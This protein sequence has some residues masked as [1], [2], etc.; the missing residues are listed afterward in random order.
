[1]SS[2]F[3]WKCFAQL[4][5]VY[6]LGWCFFVKRKFAQKLA[7]WKMLVK[8]TK[9]RLANREKILEQLINTF[10]NALQDEFFEVGKKWQRFCIF[11][12]VEKSLWSAVDSFVHFVIRGYINEMFVIRV[13]NNHN[14]FLG[15]C[16]ECFFS[17]E[18]TTHLHFYSNWKCF[19]VWQKITSSIVSIN[20]PFQTVW[21]SQ[22]HS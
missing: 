21:N 12:V 10:D 11:T 15:I 18:M 14:T 8:L 7:V 13:P 1:M 5:P 9:G 3:V 6:S 19:T 16:V 17:T 2:F 20:I 4:L 22:C